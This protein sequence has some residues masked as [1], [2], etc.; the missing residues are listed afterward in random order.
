MPSSLTLTSPNEEDYAQ[1]ISVAASR[2]EQP[3]ALYRGQPKSLR[4]LLNRA[5]RAWAAF[6]TPPSGAAPA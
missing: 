2:Y 1:A 3:V 5:A 4:A 6:L